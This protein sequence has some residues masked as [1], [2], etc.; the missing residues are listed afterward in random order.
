MAKRKKKKG[1]KKKRMPGRIKS[2]P[3]KGQ[4]KKK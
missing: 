4:F 3:R 1:R 2:G